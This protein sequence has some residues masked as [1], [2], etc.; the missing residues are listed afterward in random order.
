MSPIVTDST[1]TGYAGSGSA[2][3][4]LDYGHTPMIAPITAYDT[5]R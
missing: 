5:A 2:H 4:R 1:S 3:E